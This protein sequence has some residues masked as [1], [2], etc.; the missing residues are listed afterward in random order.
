MSSFYWWPL[1]VVIGFLFT[2]WYFWFRHRHVGFGMALGW[3]EKLQ[4]PVV[5]SRLIGSPAHKH[6]V[7]GKMVLVSVDDLTFDSFSEFK[8][9]GDSF[10]PK[11]GEMVKFVFAGPDGRHKANMVATIITSRIPIYWDPNRSELE[12]IPEEVRLHRHYCA[13]VGEHYFRARLTGEA[14]QGV[15]FS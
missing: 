8:V 15:F 3:S 13:K 10:H 12:P 9:W 6:G 5:V 11:P 4:A 7:Q 14:I 2:L 1:G